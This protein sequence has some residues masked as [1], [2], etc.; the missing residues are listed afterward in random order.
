M[1]EIVASKSLEPGGHEFTG[2]FIGIPSGRSS[3]R[4]ETAIS[5][6]ETTLLLEREGIRGDFRVAP[7]DVYIEQARSALASLFVASSC[8]HMLCIDDDL[9]WDA[10]DVLRLLAAD[11]DFV[12]AGYRKKIDQEI[13]TVTP[14]REASPVC[15]HCGCI[16]MKRANVGF[17]LIHRSVF[18]RL[19]EAHPELKCINPPKYAREIKD[20]YYVI[21]HSAVEDGMLWEEDDMFCRRWA[22]IGGR[23]WLD[24]A[25]NL[26][27]YGTK[28]WTGDI[29]RLFVAKDK[30]KREPIEITDEWEKIQGWL[31]V[32]Q[33]KALIER[34]EELPAGAKILELG[35]WRGRST[36]VLG[37]AAAKADRGIRVYAVDHF[38][39]SPSQRADA[40]R[41]ATLDD[42]GVYPDFLENMGKLG[43]LGHTVIPLRE[44]HAI[45]V[46]RMK[47]ESVDLVFL[48][49]DHSA[50]ATTGLFKMVEPKLKPG[51]AI[52]IHD[53]DW[54]EVK[55]DIDGMG[56]KV[57]EVDDMAIWRKEEK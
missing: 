35:S 52:V 14:F 24:P 41:D 30:P 21:F 7:N 29:G 57:T 9:Q 31:T 54:D 19:F 5:L 32:L 1:S 13:Y 49:G 28:G 2:M 16:E 3:P 40:M 33:A 48:D 53:Y 10:K 4:L 50:G 25:I 44:D 11:K 17:A 39:G 34:V 26:T 42:D 56:L 55:A 20:N 23:M 18:E 36:A 46:G 12:C 45:A 43:L 8:S 27:H 15:P 47:D 38:E 22:R 6:T 37:M 51:G